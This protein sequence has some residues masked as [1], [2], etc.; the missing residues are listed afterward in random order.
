MTLIGKRFAVILLAS[1][2]SIATAADKE[3]EQLV[4][5]SASSYP[6]KQTSE[7]ITVA[8]DVYETGD[9]V[10]TAFGKHNPYDYGVLPIMVVIDNHSP[11]AIR[12]DRMTVEYD[13]PGHGK[14]EATPANELRYLFGAKQPRPNPS[15]RTHQEKSSQRLGDRGP[16]VCRQDDPAQRKRQRLLLLSD[17]PP[18]EFQFVSHRDGRGRHGAGT[19]VLRDSAGAGSVA[20]IPALF[21]AQ[22]GVAFSV[23]IA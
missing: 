6:F 19:A 5:G 3:H 2:V 9:K 20:P 18:L 10:K 11:K 13:M 7:G 15:R 16:S 17:R 22:I 8:A 4:V 23:D 1:I 21:L 12:V 14:V